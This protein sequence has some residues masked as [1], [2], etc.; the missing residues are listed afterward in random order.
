MK[1]ILC[2]AVCILLIG[3]SSSLMASTSADKQ[4]AIDK[5]LAHLAA[6]QNT[7]GSWTDGYGGATFGVADTAAALLAF[8]EQ[9]YKP[10]GWHG[11]DY[12]TVVTKATNYILRAYL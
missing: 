10:L 5:G 3:S 7:N 6:T 9:E 8:T 12:S 1:K 11:T 4:A 2:G